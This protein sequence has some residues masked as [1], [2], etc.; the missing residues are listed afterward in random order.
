MNYWE[1]FFDDSALY[2]LDIK[3]REDPI[4]SYHCFRLFRRALDTRAIEQ[5]VV[6]TDIETVNWWGREERSKS[7]AKVSMPMRQHYAQPET[8]IVPFVCYTSAM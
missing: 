5:K 4:D 2:P 7:N 3:T 8:L 1:I 6:V